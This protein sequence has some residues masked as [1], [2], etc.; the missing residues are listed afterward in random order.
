MRRPALELRIVPDDLWTAAHT[1]LATVRRVCL[2]GTNGRPF[3][4]PPLGASSKYLL[5]NL[6]LC[7]CCG[8]PLKVLLTCLGSSDQ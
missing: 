1:R 6:A 4:R 8:G 2:E 7:G 5:T 3:G